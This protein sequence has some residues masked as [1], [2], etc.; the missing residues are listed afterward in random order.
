M[1]NTRRPAV[2]TICYLLLTVVALLYAHYTP[3][4]SHAQE[5][6]YLEFT[7]NLSSDFIEV[8]KVSMPSQ[9]FIPFNDFVSGV[10]LWIDNSGGSGAAT[11]EMRRV[12]DNALITSKLV[13]IPT[14]PAVWGGQKFHVAFDSALL[15]TNNS[16]YKINVISSMPN[17]RLYYSNPTDIREHNSERV[18]DAS[19]LPAYLGSD[20]QGFA[21]KFALYESN[22]NRPPVISNATAT[23]LSQSETQI[24]FNANEPVDY[25]V[26][27]ALNGTTP[28]SGTSF[29]GFYSRCNAEITTCTVLVL[30]DPNT[31]YDYELIAQDEWGNEDSVSESFTSLEESSSSD[32]SNNNGLILSITNTSISS[33]DNNSATVSWDTNV[34][35]NSSMLIT[36]T[37]S[38]GTQVVISV[39]DAAYKLNHSLTTGSVLQP[40]TQYSAELISTDAAGNSVEYNLAF[41][42]TATQPGNGGDATSTDNTSGDTPSNT[43][44]TSNDSTSSVGYTGEVTINVETSSDGSS[45]TIGWTVPESGAPTDGYRID[46]FD[47]DNNLRLAI[48]TDTNEIVIPDLP[49]GDYKAVVYANNGGVFDRLSDPIPFSIPGLTT[50]I[51]YKTRVYSIIII[52]ILLLTLSLAFMDIRRKTRVELKRKR[53]KKK[54]DKRAAERV[55]K[56]K[57]ELK[58]SGFT[59]VEVVLSIGILVSAIAIIGVFGRDVTDLSVDYTQRFVAQQEIDLTINEMMTEMRSIS[60]SNEGSYPIAIAS[61]SAITFYTD[62]QGDGLV[63][64]VRYYLEGTTLKKGVIIPSGDPLQYNPGS[65]VV[66]DVVQNISMGTSTIFSYYDK[67]FSGSEPPLVQPVTI[68]DIRM[69]GVSLSAKDVSQIAPVSFSIRITPRNLRDNL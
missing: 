33:L 62:R 10:D 39:G 22:D 51:S 54:A 30:T 37:N 60:Q 18:P 2:R 66:R 28:T 12:S 20:E 7:S 63:E 15:V 3:P 40:E 26:L 57:K 34:V 69:I 50:T 23:I 43:S 35:A 68:S 6:K 9:Q 11:V 52:S 36:F 29:R 64:K 47:A 8:S 49:A 5:V 4:I 27:F 55:A 17:L 31:G 24:S 44:T 61:S 45:V 19:V 65:E 48:L 58:E 32:S 1:I 67:N 46:I 14:I 56:R 13:T 16:A 59:L 25:R 41:T 42:T 53:A 21:F 38:L